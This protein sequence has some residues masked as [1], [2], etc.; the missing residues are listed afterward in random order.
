MIMFVVLGITALV[1]LPK[2]C[3]AASMD[4]DIGKRTLLCYLDRIRE[5]PV[6]LYPLTP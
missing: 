1:E 5:V 4:K 2:N 6:S 3:I